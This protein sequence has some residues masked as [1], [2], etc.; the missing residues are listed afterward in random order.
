MN[1][2][3][4]A[5][6]RGSIRIKSFA[7]GHHDLNL[8]ISDLK[9]VK[10]TAKAYM[11]AQ[12]T[13]MKDMAKWASKEHNKAIFG[14]FNHILQLSKL[15]TEVQT[16]FLDELNKFRSQFDGILEAEQVV[17]AA[18]TKLVNLQDKEQKLTKDLKK[19][20][21]RTTLTGVREIKQKIDETRQSIKTT[22]DEI[23][24]RLIENESMKVIRVKKGLSRLSESYLN[25]AKKSEVI[26]IAQKGITDMLPNTERMDRN[27][28]QDVRQAGDEQAKYIVKR[29]DE[30]LKQYK[31]RLSPY[32]PEAPLSSNSDSP[33]PYSAVTSTN[34]S[35][36][37]PQLQI[38][39][40]PTHEYDLPPGELMEQ[41]IL[42]AVGGIRVSNF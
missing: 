35:F 17:D 32:R 31:M 34:F 12:E 11:E 3:T 42:G 39:Y 25:L 26:F 7:A 2:A 30:R 41:D 29:A 5:F 38:S 22:Q 37:S 10:V 28:L 20:D 18:K 23:S 40:R 13:A 9:Q 16:D 21:V 14:S 36:S 19:T 24:E 15:W 8:I 33:P 27:G 1:K 4:K 6:R